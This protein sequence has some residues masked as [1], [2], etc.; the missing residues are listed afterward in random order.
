[1]P[2]EPSNSA[3][4]HGASTRSRLEWLGNASNAG[5]AKRICQFAAD[6]GYE[7]APVGLA[8]DPR[9]ADEAIRQHVEA[10]TFVPED[11]D[12]DESVGSVPALAQRSVASS[13][14]G[15]SY[16]TVGSDNLDWEYL[17][18]ETEATAP[19]FIEAQALEEEGSA[20]PHLE[21]GSNNVEVDSDKITPTLTWQTQVH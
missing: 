17:T 10:G 1:M 7:Q 13:S 21:L 9:L 5:L 8:F 2:L 6:E 16:G 11:N 12:N 14:S 18:D 3:L 15:G 4:Q 20:F 19:F